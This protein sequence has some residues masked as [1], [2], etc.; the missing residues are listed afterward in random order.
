MGIENLTKLDQQIESL[1]PLIPLLLCLASESIV[2]KF[3]LHAIR[4]LF[5]HS[6]GKTKGEIFWTLR[7]LIYVLNKD[8]FNFLKKTVSIKIKFYLP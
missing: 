5:L 1:E 6:E 7:A 8:V 2:S 3:L 4:D